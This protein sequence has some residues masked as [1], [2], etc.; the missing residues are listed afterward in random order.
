MAS[1]ERLDCRLYQRLCHLSTKQNHY[2]SKENPTLWNHSP[3]RCPTFQTNSHGFNHGPPPQK[4]QRCHPHYHRPWLFTGGSLPPM[5][6][7]HHGTWYC[8]TLFG[9]RLSM[10][11]LTKE[12]DQR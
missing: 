1:N 8:S 6:N 10:V 11:W 3:L 4:W 2:P 7:K 9:E 12:D 5:L